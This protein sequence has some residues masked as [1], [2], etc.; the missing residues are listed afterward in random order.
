MDKE[1]TAETLLEV[2]AFAYK[3]MSRQEIALI[4][5]VSID[6]LKDEE[7]PA[8]MAFLKGRLMRKAEFNGA[9]IQLTKQLSSPAMAIEKGIAEST[10]LND[11]KR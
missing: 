10:Y 9:V 8:G 11:I 6:R 7:D 4:T 2:E 3:Y 5:G 1:I